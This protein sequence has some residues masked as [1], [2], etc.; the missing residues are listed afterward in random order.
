M[1]FVSQMPLS[2]EQ[3]AD[4]IWACPLIHPTVTFKRDKILF[5]G[6]YQHQASRRQ[7]DYELWFRCLKVGLVFANLPDVLIYYRFTS[8]SQQKQRLK[9]AI[10]QA[11]IGWNGCRMLNLPKWQYLAVMAPILRAIFPPGLSH[12]IYR[13]LAPFDPRKKEK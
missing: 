9:Q 1:M 13:S 3:I 12:L 2:H 4:S 11:Q 5:A 7:E 6:N 10:Y 8:K